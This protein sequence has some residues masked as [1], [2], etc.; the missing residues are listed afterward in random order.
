MTAFRVATRTSS[1]RAKAAAN[2]TAPS[3][4]ATRTFVS[5]RTAVRPVAWSRLWT[6]APRMT[7]SQRRSTSGGSAPSE[8]RFSASLRRR[9]SSPS[10]S[11]RASMSRAKRASS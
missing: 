9:A 6:K 1:L 4:A 11:A 5:H 10:A 7:A 3:I 8:S 2:M